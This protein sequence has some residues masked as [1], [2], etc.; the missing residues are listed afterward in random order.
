MVPCGRR[1]QR[2]AS[3][4]LR[5]LTAEQAHSTGMPFEGMCSDRTL[6]SGVAQQPLAWMLA[7]QQSESPAARGVAFCKR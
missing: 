7:V 5:T 2:A 1:I 4:N 6:S 3:M